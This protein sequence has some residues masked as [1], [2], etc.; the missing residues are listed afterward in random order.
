MTSAWAIRRQACLPAEAA[1]GAKK[2]KLRGRVHHYALFASLSAGAIL[3]A[4]TKTS[5]ARVAVVVF[6]TTVVLQF[7]ISSTYHMYSWPPRTERWL[8]R[9]DHSCIFLLIAG[10]YTPICR[11]KLEGQEGNKLLIMVWAGASLGVMQSLFWISAPKLLT[12]LLYLL[13]GWAGTQSL[14]HVGLRDPVAILVLL[15]GLSY[16]I[17]VLCYAFRWPGKVAQTW[18]FHEHFHLFVVG[19]VGLHFAA[20]TMLVL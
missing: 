17:G 15:G 14:Y 3:L 4:A 9:M 7:L 11:L 12:S 1:H 19:G 18:G 16:S 13:L 2:P 6:L 8:R 10:T 20:V 5:K